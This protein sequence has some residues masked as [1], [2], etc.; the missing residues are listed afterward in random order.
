MS[1]SDYYVALAAGRVE[2]GLIKSLETTG[3]AD[4]GLVRC[5]VRPD[6]DGHDDL[7]LLADALADGRLGGLGVLE[8]V[9][10]A[11]WQHHAHRGRRGYGSGLGGR[12]R[13]DRRRR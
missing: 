5:A 7:A 8:I 3:L 6:Q 12:W 9:G 2:S 13:N 1:A 10:I 11:G 4:L